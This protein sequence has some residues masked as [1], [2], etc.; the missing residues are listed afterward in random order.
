MVMSFPRLHGFSPNR[1]PSGPYSFQLP[2]GCRHDHGMYRPSLK[3]HRSFS[4]SLR[5]TRLDRYSGYEHF[6]PPEGSIR[7]FAVSDCSL[8]TLSHLASLTLTLLIF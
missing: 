7:P 5:S 8:F 1:N 2:L 4:H 6:P 3:T